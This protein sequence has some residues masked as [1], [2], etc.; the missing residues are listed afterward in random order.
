MQAFLT[1][2]KAGSHLG[3]FVMRHTREMFIEMIQYMPR[4]EKL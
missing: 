2:W 3:S 4:E 1:A